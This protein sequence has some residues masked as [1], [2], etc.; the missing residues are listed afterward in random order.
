M[1]IETKC[2]KT[3]AKIC[4]MKFD[5]ES[6]YVTIIFEYWIRYSTENRKRLND[7]LSIPVYS[8]QID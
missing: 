2:F 1:H 4:K 6:N 7:K 3:C 8:T 5:V